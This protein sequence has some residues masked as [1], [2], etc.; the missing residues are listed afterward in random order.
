MKK[1]Q[2]NSIHGWALQVALA[3]ALLSISAV[4]VASSFNASPAAMTL[5]STITPAGAGHNQLV[6]AGPAS[7]GGLSPATAPFTFGNTGSLGAARFAHTATLLS[8]GK[9]LV[10]GGQ[11]QQLLE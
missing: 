11:H 3:I 1:Q 8:S 6:T 10:A 2:N 9:V 5:N 7:F 4:L